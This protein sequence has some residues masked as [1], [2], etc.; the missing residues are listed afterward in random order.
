MLSL[1]TP[2]FQASEIQS[3]IVQLN[4]KESG[5]LDWVSSDFYSHTLIFSL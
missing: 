2:K 3:S 5:N 4:S 1:A